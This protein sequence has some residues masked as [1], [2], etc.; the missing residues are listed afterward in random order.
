MREE[1]GFCE[2]CVFF[3]PY[4]LSYDYT[5]IHTLVFDSEEE[6]CLD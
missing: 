2:V 4:L 1:V 5:R 3:F 6:K